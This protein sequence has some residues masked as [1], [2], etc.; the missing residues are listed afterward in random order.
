MGFLQARVELRSACAA[1]LGEPRHTGRLRGRR[2]GEASASAHARQ[3]ALA[4]GLVVAV[5]TCCGPNI[6]AR[7][8]PLIMRAAAVGW[9]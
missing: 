9:L 6:G 4:R 3:P 1:A 8:A 7:C 5:A 2:A